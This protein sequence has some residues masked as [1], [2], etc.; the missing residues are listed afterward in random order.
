[1][2]SL[3]NLG[4]VIPYGRTRPVKRFRTLVLVNQWVSLRELR[5]CCG[6][7]IDADIL[8]LS[9]SPIVVQGLEI[10]L[11]KAISCSDIVPIGLAAENEA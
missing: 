9:G 4:N 8:K 5:R 10:A 6:D 11:I 1:M 7:S 2:F 3:R